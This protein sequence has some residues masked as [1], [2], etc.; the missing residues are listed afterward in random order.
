MPPSRHRRRS[1]G[2]PISPCWKRTTSAR[3]SLSTR[4]FIALR[5]ALPS[6][7]KPFVTFAYKTGWRE[8]EIADLTWSQV[9]LE[10]GI[11]R[12]EPGPP[13]TMR[14]ARSILDERTAGDFQEPTGGAQAHPQVDR[15]RLPQ[16]RR[17]R[18]DQGFPLQVERGLQ[19]RRAGLRLPAGQENMLKSGRRSCRQVLSCTTSAAR[20]FATWCVPVCLKRWP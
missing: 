19:E 18:Q 16:P 15:I 2:C 1:S 6:Y 5:D 9:D 13:R 8:S 20:R 11:V 14:A 4:T 7:L 3:G 10:A 17:H 12:L